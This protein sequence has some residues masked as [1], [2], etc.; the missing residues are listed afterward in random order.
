LT[1]GYTNGAVLDTVPLA[2]VFPL[3]VI[4][5]FPFVV[6]GVGYTDI[7]PPSLILLEQLNGG[8]MCFAKL[9]KYGYGSKKKE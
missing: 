3:L 7:D 1:Y 4:M 5:K 2:I 8:I 6:V 9:T